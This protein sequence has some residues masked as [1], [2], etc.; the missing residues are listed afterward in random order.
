MINA[1]EHGNLGITYAE[2]TELVLGGRWHAEVDRRLALPENA[3]KKVEVHFSRRPAAFEVT[4]RDQGK[5]FDFSR[6]LD[7]DPRRLF[8]PHGRGIAM[9]RADCFDS[10][11]YQAPGNVVRVRIDVPAAPIAAAPA[12][13]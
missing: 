7:F 4:I 12:L 6:Y 8:D 13:Q 3:P 10:V 1:V 5:G 9:A 11:E 2:K